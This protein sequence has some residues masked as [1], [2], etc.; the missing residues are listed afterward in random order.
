MRQQKIRL[1]EMRENGTRGLLAN[2]CDYQCGHL[3]KLAPERVDQWPDDARI[4][5]F[6]M[7]FVC[8]K[9]GLR[10]ADLRP[11]FPPPS[12]GNCR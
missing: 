5:D 9:C 6:E 10:G 8:T 12:M 3:L 1:G 2:C 4:S 7:R 11:D